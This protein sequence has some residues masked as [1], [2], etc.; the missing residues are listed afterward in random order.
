MNRLLLGVLLFSL[1]HLAVAVAPALRQKMASGIGN[2]PFRGLFSLVQLLA[3]YLMVSGWS[4]ASTAFVYAPLDGGRWL[5]AILMFAGAILFFAPY[6]PNNIRCFLR[7]PQL[8][9]VLC[10]SAAHLASNGDSRSLI[11]FGGLGAWAI[12]Q[13]YFLNRRDVAWQRPARARYLNDALLVLFG[14]F[15]FSL[16]AWFHG[17]LFGVPPFPNLP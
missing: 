12:L 2:Q 9:G 1:T 15:I 10:W 3:V 13:I 14:A 17:A 5:P 8:L 7:H 6:A 11:L 16:L 4:S